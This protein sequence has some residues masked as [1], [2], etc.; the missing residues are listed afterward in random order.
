MIPSKV[1]SKVIWAD[2]GIEIRLIRRSKNENGRKDPLY[3][4]FIMFS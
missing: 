3:L 4:E 1:L 2:D